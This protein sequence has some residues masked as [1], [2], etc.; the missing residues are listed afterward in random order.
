MQCFVLANATREDAL[1]LAEYI[2]NVQLV[3]IDIIY[4]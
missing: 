1:L 4:S 2:L 3:I